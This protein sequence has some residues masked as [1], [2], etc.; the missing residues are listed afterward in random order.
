M[1]MIGDMLDSRLLQIDAKSSSSLA[2]SPTNN[3]LVPVV[4]SLVILEVLPVTEHSRFDLLG[5]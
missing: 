4:S 1:H 2:I 3:T 5:K